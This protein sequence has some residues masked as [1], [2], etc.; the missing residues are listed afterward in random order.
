MLRTTP[1]PG[2]APVQRNR[3]LT[4]IDRGKTRELTEVHAA[5]RCQKARASQR[6]ARKKALPKRT[7]ICSAR[8]GVESRFR[9]WSL[10]DAELAPSRSAARACA[11]GECIGQFE[12]SAP[13]WTGRG[14]WWSSPREPGG[15]AGR[16]RNRPHQRWNV[17]SRQCVTTELRGRDR[18][19]CTTSNPPHRRRGQALGVVISGLGQDARY[20]GP[21]S[22]LHEDLASKHPTSIECGWPSCS[23]SARRGRRFA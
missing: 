10:C 3:R 15:S 7:S 1:R 23:I 19:S 11:V 12:L 5:C 17:L 14:G 22:R 20:V 21:K 2:E 9:F 6:S 18:K 16:T 4:C 13:V 8:A